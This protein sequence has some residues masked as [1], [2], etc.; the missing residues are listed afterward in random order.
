MPHQSARLRA[1]YRHA[2]SAPSNRPDDRSP[3]PVSMLG[4]AE[5]ADSFGTPEIALRLRRVLTQMALH[6]LAAGPGEAEPRPPEPE[7]G[8]AE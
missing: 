5:P 7:A 2:A 1:S 4:L 6:V 8:V 3:A